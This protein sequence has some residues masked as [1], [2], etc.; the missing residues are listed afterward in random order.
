MKA[1]LAP[2]NIAYFNRLLATASLWRASVV[3][4]GCGGQRGRP[5][6]SGPLL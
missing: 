3:G 4:R 6:R 2:R 1:V 5:R